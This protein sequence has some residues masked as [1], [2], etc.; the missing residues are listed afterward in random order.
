MVTRMVKTLASYSDNVNVF[1]DPLLFSQL[2][3]WFQ[4]LPHCLAGII[5]GLRRRMARSRVGE[6]C[7]GSRWRAAMTIDPA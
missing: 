4:Q 6:S 1:P 5:A 7:A 2:G 3:Q